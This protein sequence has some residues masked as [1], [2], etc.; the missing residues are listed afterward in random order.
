MAP[1]DVIFPDQASVA[2][3]F[4]LAI[5]VYTEYFVGFLPMMEFWRKQTNREWYNRIAI[6]V[7]LMPP[8]IVF[9]IVWLIAY[10]IL[11]VGI[12]YFYR[13]VFYDVGTGYAADAIGILFIIH[14]MLNKSWTY[15]FFYMKQQILALI[16]LIAMIL[17]LIA[18]IIILGL[19]PNWQSFGLI[20]VYL[21]WLC[22]ALYL[23]L[24]WLYHSYR[25]GVKKSTSTTTLMTNKTIA[26]TSNVNTMN[27]KK[28]KTISN[29]ISTTLP[30]SIVNS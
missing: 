8:G 9:G 1:T 30:V 6:H 22:F 2:M 7:F 26:T 3:F 15:V 21:V 18:I 29:N 17:T 27:K 11:W 28:K 24:S 14:I 23:S 20:L 13:N 16:M 10:L 25:I 12:W 4:V 5:I 19:A